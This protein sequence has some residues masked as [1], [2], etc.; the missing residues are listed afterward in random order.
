MIQSSFF[1]KHNEINGLRSFL[2][3]V[4]VVFH[5]AVQ[6]RGACSFQSCKV[7]VRALASAISQNILYHFNFLKN[8]DYH[9]QKNIEKINVRVL[10]KSDH[11]RTP[12]KMV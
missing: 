5:A 6:S 1:Q 3:T 4:R 10:T 8:F 9:F 12:A 7:G 11:F 2:L